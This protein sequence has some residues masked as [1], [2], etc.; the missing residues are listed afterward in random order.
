M[1]HHLA[2]LPSLVA[3]YLCIRAHYLPTDLNQELESL[4]REL[5]TN[6]RQLRV[7]G[8]SLVDGRHM[9]DDQPV[10]DE[11]AWQSH[12]WAVER[13]EVN[14]DDDDGLYMFATGEAKLR[15]IPTAAGL[16]VRQALYK[17]EYDDEGWE[18]IL[19]VLLSPTS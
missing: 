18:D 4:A 17:I 16:K 7:V 10:W 14:L 19:S 3:I 2:R 12:W 8:I 15:G 11:E 13:E 1:L 5:A 6:N 9:H